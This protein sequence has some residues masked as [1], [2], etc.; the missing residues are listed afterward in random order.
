MVK[1]IKHIALAFTTLVILSSAGVSY[2]GHAEILIDAESGLIIHEED[3]NHSWYPASLTKVM[4]LYMAFTALNQGQVGLQD[5]MPVSHH[6]AKQPTSKLGLRTGESITVEEAILAIITRSAND[7]TVVLAEYIGG[8]E[9]NFAARMTA[10]AHTLGMYDSHFM[11]ATG[12]PHQWQV[13]TARDLGLLAWRIRRDFPNFYAYFAA[14][15]FYFKGREL[16]GINK[17]TATFPGA[18]GMKTGFTCGSG[19]NLMSSAQQNG[20][21][22]IGVVLGGM[23]SSQRYQL[24][25]DMMNRG[26]Q[27]QF[28]EYSTKNITTI[29]GKFVGSAPYQL[30]CGKGAPN[31]QQA[32]VAPTK[33]H[34]YHRLTHS[35]TRSKHLVSRAKPS[36]TTKAKVVSRQK[37]SKTRYHRG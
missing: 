37:A 31:V 20:R 8:N 9:E 32:S 4:T 16:T 30:G 28:T 1:L 13:T 34:S 22:L 25:T 29:P 5:R 33:H 7:A 12:L 17:F 10:K 19:Y 18:E 14:H 24:M 6:A 3:A 36:K 11:N 27:N 26:F 2:A 35:K 15:S 23:S 21:R